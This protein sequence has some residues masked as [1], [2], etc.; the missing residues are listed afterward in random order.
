MERHSIFIGG[1]AAGFFGAIACARG[2]DSNHRVTILEG[3]ARPLTKVKVSGGGRC[4]VT[5]SCFDPK[6]LVKNYPRG[7]K[8]ML[9]PFSR[10]GPEQMVA[11][12]K[13]EGVETHAEADGRMFPKTNNSQTIIDCLREAAD[14]AGV[15]LE[16]GQLVKSIVKNGELFQI[17]TNKGEYTANKVMLATGSM[18]VGHE[19]A[20]NLG[21]K[22]TKLVPSLFTF[23]CNHP[24]I[25][26]LA[27]VAQPNAEAVVIVGK[28]KHKQVGPVLITHWGFSGPAILKNS[29]FAAI[30]L[31]DT[32]YKGVLRL[33]WLPEFNIESL[34]D[35]LVKQKENSPKKMIMTSS[36]IDL[37]KRLWQRLVE[38]ADLDTSSWADV[39]KT[40]LL[41][42]STFICQGEYPING[43]SVFKDEFVTCGGINPKEV[44][45]KTL[46]SKIV[47]GFYFAGEVLNVDGITGGYNFQNAWATS[48]I[49]GNHMAGIEA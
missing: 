35:L 8:E 36:P 24:I 42:L 11:W 31:F 43:R 38:L 48:Y 17:K 49:G 1:G 30:D 32:E 25:D 33:N 15:V 2:A 10:F 34:C 39:S 29:A 47:S 6:E 23:N 40:K 9:G 21:H 13:A 20:I 28:K 45:F 27:G 4:N 44:N 46:E 14:R 37:P 19:L 16:K 3:T 12:L 22:I 41:K 7:R 26:G 18:P 5:T